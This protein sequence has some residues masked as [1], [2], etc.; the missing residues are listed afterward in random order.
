[1]RCEKLSRLGAAVNELEEEKLSFSNAS[2]RQ[3]NNHWKKEC[4]VFESFLGAIVGRDSRDKAAFLLYHLRRLYPDRSLISICVD[5]FQ[6]MR[7]FS[8]LPKDGRKSRAP[9]Y[10]V[11]DNLLS[12]MSGSLEQ[13]VHRKFLD[14]RLAAVHQME[15]DYKP[16]F[17][18][19]S[20]RAVLE[21]VTSL[22]VVNED[23]LFSEK[24]EKQLNRPGCKIRHRIFKKMMVI[25]AG[26]DALG[27][28]ENFVD[29]Q[30]KKLSS[31]EE[32]YLWN[33]LGRSVEKLDPL[34]QFESTEEV[35][36]K[37]RKKYSSV[38]NLINKVCG[39]KDSLRA[40]RARADFLK[41]LFPKVF[42]LTWGKLLEEAGK[43]WGSL[44]EKPGYQLISISKAL[45][46]LIEKFMGAGEIEAFFTKYCK[47]LKLTL[48]QPILKRLQEL[49][50]AIEEEIQRCK[51]LSGEYN[52]RFLS[53][54]YT[55]VLA[56]IVTPVEK[57]FTHRDLKSEGWK[58]GKDRYRTARKR[59]LDDSFKEIQPKKRGR[60][61]L[62]EEIK[63]KIAQEWIDNSR[64]AANLEVK[65]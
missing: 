38:K 42:E 62:D 25:C 37:N 32:F 19:R 36:N 57:E 60:V 12:K 64:A 54:L 5:D 39:Y 49:A 3:K 26:T 31:T 29:Q 6:E 1:M 45:L 65:Y 63:Q 50:N 47:K 56:C 18:A 22:N 27:E 23:V 61:E 24:T 28:L 7:N 14:A 13:E 43:N 35:I 9:T 2:K 58:I 55:N 41:H 30:L 46:T 44:K 20:W 48:K 59:Q 8:T 15:E 11:F 51:S 34:Q 17:R 16:L 33:R 52:I 10:R 21:D 4:E 40:R 53:H